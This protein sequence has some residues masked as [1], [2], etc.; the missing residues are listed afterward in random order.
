MLVTYGSC[1]DV[2]PM[3]GGYVM[4]STE[5]GGTAPAVGNETSVSPSETCQMRAAFSG[6]RSGR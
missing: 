6:L 3:T 2:E 5:S 1:G 4:S